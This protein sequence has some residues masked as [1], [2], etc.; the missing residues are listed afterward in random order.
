[1]TIGSRVKDAIQRRSGATATGAGAA[2]AAGGDKSVPSLSELDKAVRHIEVLARQLNHVVAKETACLDRS[3]IEGFKDLQ[4]EKVRLAK[5]YEMFA[6][7]II[8]AREKLKELDEKAIA[9]LREAQETFMGT[10]RE[11]A[12][13]LQR[14]LASTRRLNERIMAS[15]RRALSGEDEVRYSANGT[16]TAIQRKAPLSTGV[17]DT[18]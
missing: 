5:D 10:A 9:A 15:A 4:A 3:D 6:Q 14:R 2:A 7:K 8:S 18:A 11:N 12:V 16:K 17:S 1:M 13:K